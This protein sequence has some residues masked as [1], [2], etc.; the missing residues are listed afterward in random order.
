MVTPAAKTDGRVATCDG[1]KVRETETEPLTCGPHL[2]GRTKKRTEAVLTLILYLYLI[3]KQGLLLPCFFVR[4]DMWDPPVSY[5]V[6][7]I[8]LVGPTCQS[9]TG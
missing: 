1:R 4:P 9:A 2:S 6:A 8:I 5:R 7:H 3:L